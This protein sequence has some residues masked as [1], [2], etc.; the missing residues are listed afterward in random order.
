MLQREN[1]SH[2]LG[3]AEDSAAPRYRADQSRPSLTLVVEVVVTR[4]YEVT[5]FHPKTVA[6]HIYTISWQVTH[7]VLQIVYLHIHSYHS[8]QLVIVHYTHTLNHRNHSVRTRSA[9]YTIL[10]LRAQLRIINILLSHAT[11]A[12][13][14]TQLTRQLYRNIPIQLNYI[15]KHKRQHH[16]HIRTLYHAIAH[17]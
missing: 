8:I 6:V 2:S 17:T 12:C 1:Y 7:R 14:T 3:G 11:L 10:I 5:V 15:L 4:I 9:I 13:H 16:T